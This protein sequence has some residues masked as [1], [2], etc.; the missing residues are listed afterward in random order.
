MGFP[1]S[2]PYYEPADRGERVAA[3]VLNVSRVIADLCY[4]DVIPVQ[5]AMLVTC[6][7]GCIWVTELRGEDI[8]L[9]E[10]GTHRISS[11][12]A[13]IQALRPASVLLR[14]TPPEAPAGLRRLLKHAPTLRPAS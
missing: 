3:M 6:L 2:Q 1:Q 5:N 4:R 7:Q 10:G 12:Q 14:R 9:E 8:V 11:G 13:V